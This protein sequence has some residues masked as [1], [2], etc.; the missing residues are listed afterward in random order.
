[1]N[2]QN[3]GGSETWSRTINNNVKRKWY[4]TLSSLKQPYLKHNDRTC[5]TY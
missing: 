2:G 5:L 3:E 4:C 1:M